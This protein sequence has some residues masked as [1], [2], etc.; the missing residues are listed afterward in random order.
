MEWDTINFFKYILFFKSFLGPQQNWA[1]G[2]EN[3]MMPDNS[4][5]PPMSF[6]PFQAA[7]LV[8]ELRGSKSK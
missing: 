7:A 8:L 3:I 2:P 1:E 6:M 5:F 4:V